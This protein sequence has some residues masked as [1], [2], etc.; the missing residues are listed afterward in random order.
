[1]GI[2]ASVDNM[3]SSKFVFPQNL[4]TVKANTAFTVKMA[5]RGLTT[6]NFVNAAANYFSAPQQI[7]DSGNIKGHSH[8]VIEKVNGIKDTTPTDPTKFAFFKGLNDAAEGGVLS[9]EVTDGLPE[10]TYRIASINSAANHQPVLVAV[11]QHG[12]LDDMVYVRF[13][14]FKFISGQN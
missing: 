13:W 12:S 9:A 1:M 4:D 14:P 5:I 10:G 6:G 7:D 3:P 8:I 11:A 2:I